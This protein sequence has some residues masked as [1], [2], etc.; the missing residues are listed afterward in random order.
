M[1][2]PTNLHLVIDVGDPDTVNEK[3][4]S[5][6]A[7][8]C[9]PDSVSAMS[10]KSEKTHTAQ[11]M[12]NFADLTNLVKKKWYAKKNP[13]TSVPQAKQQ[14]PLLVTT[15]ESSPSPSQP[16]SHSPLLVPAKGKSSTGLSKPQPTELSRHATRQSSKPATCTRQDYQ[17]TAYRS[18]STQ[19]PKDR[20]QLPGLADVQPLL[21]LAYPAL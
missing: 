2:A 13:S 11:S 21:V 10:S 17:P 20:R 3:S 5:K 16:K 15:D 19:Q 12:H 6:G 4:A 8:L 14:L 7:T 1:T 9:S 18:G